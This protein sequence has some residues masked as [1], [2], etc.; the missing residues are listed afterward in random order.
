MPTTDE[1]EPEDPQEE[2]TPELVDFTQE[3][4]DGLP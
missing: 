3:F 4:L 1:Q 2:P